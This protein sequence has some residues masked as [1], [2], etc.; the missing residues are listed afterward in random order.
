MLLDIKYFQFQKKNYLMILGKK[1]RNCGGN[2]PR[3]VCLSYNQIPRVEIYPF[4]RCHLLKT[5]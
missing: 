4:G 3:S 5:A 1:F 2:T